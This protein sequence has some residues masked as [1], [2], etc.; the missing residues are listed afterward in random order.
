MFGRVPRSL[1]STEKALWF[2][3]HPSTKARRAIFL[4]NDMPQ[5]SSIGPPPQYGFLNLVVGFWRFLGE[6]ENDLMSELC[7]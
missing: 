6:A 7:I 3:I 5:V 2:K 4:K 1:S